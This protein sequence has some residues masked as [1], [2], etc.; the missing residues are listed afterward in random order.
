[1]WMLI[2]TVNNDPLDDS[3]V[4]AKVITKGERLVITA[5]TDI[6]EGDEVFI[7]YGVHYWKVKMDRLTPDQAAQVR[8]EVG[9]QGIR[10][11]VGQA[12]TSTPLERGEV[13]PYAPGV[14]RAIVKSKLEQLTE[15]ERERYILDNV[16][17]SEELAEELQYL[18]GRRYFDDESGH[19][20]EVE[21]LLHD[22]EH[23]AVIAYRRAMYGKT[24]QQDDSPFSVYGDGGV[25]QLCEVWGV[26]NGQGGIKWPD[27]EAEW[28]AYQDSDAEGQRLHR[29]CVETGQEWHGRALLSGPMTTQQEV[30]GLAGRGVSSS[31]SMLLQKVEQSACIQ[32]SA[33]S[34]GAQD[35]L[36]ATGT[37]R[38]AIQDIGEGRCGGAC[39]R[40]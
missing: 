9:A 6:H 16:E 34:G 1:M 19:L 18:V 33:G 20:Y 26:D 35:Q 15:E 27:S 12:M 25:L 10:E 23:K 31:R 32:V 8:D 37:L 14:S 30:T 21:S 13:E 17:Q 29:E 38:G 36:E 22:E 40:H 28:A 39:G 11:S 4:T 3:M 2:R 7:S 24:H 5:T